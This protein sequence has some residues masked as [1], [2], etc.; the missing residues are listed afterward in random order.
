MARRLRSGRWAA[1]AA[2]AAPGAALAQASPLS[3]DRVPPGGLASAWPLGIIVA[4][5]AAMMLIGA[6]VS[7]RRGGGH[8]PSGGPP[9]GR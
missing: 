1:A 7:R 6:W 3:G 4:L 5:V 9:R 8:G 2:W